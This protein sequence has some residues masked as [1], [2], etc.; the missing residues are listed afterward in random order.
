MKFDW[1]D[2]SALQNE[3]DVEQKL[4]YPLLVAEEPFGF[5]IAPNEI[6][7]KKNIRRLTIGKGSDRK[8]Y[9]PDYL[10][11]VGCIPIVVIEAKKPEEDLDEAYREARL[12]ATEVNAIY[13]PGIN[14]LTKVVATNGVRLIAGA[15]D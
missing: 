12:Y 13:R 1:P 10:V 6:L 2:L 3:S 7:T 4:V 14:P 9:F 5:G 8:S 15:W 11:L